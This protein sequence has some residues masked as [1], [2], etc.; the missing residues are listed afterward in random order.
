M[1]AA[2]RLI[3]APAQLASRN[4]PTVPDSRRFYTR[5]VSLTLCPACTAK[6]R[7]TLWFVVLALLVSLAVGHVLRLVFNGKQAEG[8]RCRVGP[9]I[10]ANWIGW[11]LS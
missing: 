11:R 1:D 8:S 10:K 2:A 6:R 3:R 5:L 7:N 4:K 9:C